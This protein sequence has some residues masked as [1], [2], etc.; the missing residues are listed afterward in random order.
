MN[1]INFSNNFRDVKQKIFYRNG[2]LIVIACLLVFIYMMTV[3]SPYSIEALFITIPA[4]VALIFLFYNPKLCIVLITFWIPFRNLLVGGVA[5]EGAGYEI[6]A[7]LPEP[8]RYLDTYLLIILTAKWLSR[9]IFYSEAY[10]QTPMDVP[11]LIFSSVALVS[12]L[13]NFTSPII[14]FV[15]LR[16]FLQFVLFYYAIAQLEFE[17]KFLKK[18]VI[19]YLI[20]AMIQTPISAYNFLFSEVFQEVLGDATTG[21]LQG[22]TN[23]LAHYE[24]MMM[25]IALGLIK[26]VP[27]KRFI[28]ILLFVWYMLSFFTASGR[29]AL[30][31]FPFAALF[32]TNQDIKEAIDFIKSYFI[33]F[34]ILAVAFTFFIFSGIKHKYYYDTKEA[35][36]LSALYEQSLTEE[37]YTGRTYAF[38]IAWE[39]LKEE[40]VSVLLGVGPGMFLSNTGKFFEV[41]LFQK[42][43]L[44]SLKY[45]YGEEDKLL[46]PAD[47]PVLLTEFGFLGLFAFGFILFKIYQN[48]KEGIKSFDDPF[49]KGISAGTIGMLL[50]ITVVALGERTYETIYM[51]FLLWFFVSMVYKMRLIKGKESQ[52]EKIE[53]VFYS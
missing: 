43:N 34:L 21:T 11:I 35:L 39:S 28:Y 2:L 45:G 38:T 53:R 44:E 12:A 49:W 52:N 10:I 17:E 8:M 5:S 19:L 3:V 1:R 50:I 47:I 48:V 24:G 31:I 6:F 30:Y 40:A 36:S 18:M 27:K 42:Y 41:P 9:K 4:I 37:R 22:G 13:G 14:A 7:I 23:L 25:C 16:T 32:V 26:F 29:A 46:L 15:G 20:L 33:L 51:Q